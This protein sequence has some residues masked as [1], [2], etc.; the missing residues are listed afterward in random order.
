MVQ[1][2]RVQ[3]LYA[4]DLRL[5]N[6]HPGLLNSHRGSPLK[7]LTFGAN[8]FKPK[9]TSGSEASVGFSGLRCLIWLPEEEV[10]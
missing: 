4:D 2:S 8:R 7:F 9:G 6:P 10:Y 3:G 1:N 5:P